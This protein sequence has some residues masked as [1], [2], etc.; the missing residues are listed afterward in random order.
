M[1]QCAAA[2][3]IYYFVRVC[4]FIVCCVCCL[5]KRLVT[6]T[7]I[8]LHRKTTYDGTNKPLEKFYPIWV[9]NHSNDCHQ[10]PPSPGPFPTVAW[11]FPHHHQVGHPPSPRQSITIPWKVTRN[12]QDSD[13]SSQGPSFIINRMVINN[14]QDG[15]PLFPKTVT[16]HPRTLTHHSQEAHLPLPG[17]SCIIPT[18]QGSILSKK[19]RCG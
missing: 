19:L 6:S 5:H 2:A 3:P 1:P 12:P 4:I 8:L 15:N 16:H 7:F 13:S 9:T 17:G 11:T 14:H 18:I 10:D